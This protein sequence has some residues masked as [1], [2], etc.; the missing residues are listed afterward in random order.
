MS[1]A[2]KE[3]QSL[4]ELKNIALGRYNETLEYFGEEPC[5]AVMSEQFFG[6]ISTFLVHFEVGHMICISYIDN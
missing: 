5:T 3:F 4:V 6:N 1:H 2:Q